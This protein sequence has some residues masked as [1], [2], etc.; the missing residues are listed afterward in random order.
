MIPFKPV[1]E[2]RHAGAFMAED[3]LISARQ[4][5]LADIPWMTGMT[6]EEGALKVAGKGLSILF[7]LKLERKPTQYY[8]L[9]IT[10]MEEI[11]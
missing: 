5:H 8:H 2:P 4:G 10:I 9:K 7:S 6:S 1:I 11:H 3:P